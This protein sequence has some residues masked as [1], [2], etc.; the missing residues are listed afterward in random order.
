M[1]TR[2][3]DIIVPRRFNRYTIQRSVEV[4]A[5]V[6]SGIMV[7]TPQMDALA[8]A[9]T[10][11]IDM[12][13]WN[14]LTGNSTV[15][16][17]A[18]PVTLDKLTTGTDIA[19][20]NNRTKAWGHSD[21]V[22]LLTAEDPAAATGDMVAD[23]WDR[24]MTDILLS[25]L[26]GVF[27]AAS[28]SG[29]VYDISTEDAGAVE[30]ENM[31]TATSFIDAVQLFGDN[32]SKL[33]ALAMH[34]DVQAHLEK[35]DLI[36]FERDSNGNRIGS[37]RGFPIFVDDQIAPV[38]GSEDANIYTSYIFGRGAFALGF[39]VNAM[40]AT[41]DGCIGN[42]GTE[43]VRAGL[44]HVSGMINRRRFIL[45]PRG[46]KYT[47]ASQSLQ[48]GPSNAEL[49]TSSNWVRA[50]TNRNIRMIAFRHNIA[51]PAA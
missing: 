37:Y 6:R 47:S 5:L 38:V 8:E 34:S 9:G 30:E 41:P 15:M 46:V 44:N 24:D 18:N 43:F 35:L 49:A 19:A 31:F 10:K 50:Y 2:L 26:A 1:E 7:R 40:N 27:G 23:F 32:K 48:A 4:N 42:L 11:T 17:D 25:T 22:G 12:P 13:F 14:D 45:H 33:T 3:S 16:D 51:A 29:N 28:M 36:D 39:G 21:L 20:V